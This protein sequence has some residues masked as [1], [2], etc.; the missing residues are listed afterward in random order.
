M[1]DLFQ[2]VIDGTG[3]CLDG[4]IDDVVVRADAPIFV[5]I[6]VDYTDI[7]SGGIVGLLSLNGVLIIAVQREDIACYRLD[8]VADSIQ[9]SVALCLHSSE[10]SVVIQGDG[11]ADHAALFLDEMIFYNFEPLRL[12]DEGVLKDLKD[13]IRLELAV[14][15]VGDLFDLITEVSTHS[16][17]KV[18]LVLGLENVTDAAPTGLGVDADDVGVVVTAD[19]GGIKRKCRDLSP[20]GISYLWRLRPGENR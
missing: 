14:F 12:V 20:P 4:R 8:C 17:R 9:T 3:K 13:F 2:L 5:S 15:M 18:I 11:G 10:V 19:V 6:L 1:K 16:L 7:G